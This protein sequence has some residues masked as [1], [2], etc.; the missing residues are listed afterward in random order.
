MSEQMLILIKVVVWDWED[1]ETIEVY[2]GDDSGKT[3]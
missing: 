1:M 3:W 2:L